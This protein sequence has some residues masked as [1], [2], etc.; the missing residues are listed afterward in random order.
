MP[1][2]SRASFDDRLIKKSIVKCD[3]ICLVNHS[4]KDGFTF[5]RRISYADCQQASIENNSWKIGFPHD[6]VFVPK[7]EIKYGG[8]G[9]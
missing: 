7:S 2:A 3:R 8:C 6:Q 1:I 5:L 4:R 9:K